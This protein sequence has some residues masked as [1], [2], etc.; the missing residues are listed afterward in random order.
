MRGQLRTIAV[1]R[2]L[3]ARQHGVFARRQLLEKG[4]DSKRIE[5]WLAAELIEAVYRG[6]YA[7]SR[8]LL[9][10]QGRWMAAVLASGQCAVLSH[11]SAAAHWGIRRYAGATE[12]TTP[13]KLKHERGLLRHCLP[14]SPDEVTV[15]DGIPI[16]TPG[17]TLFDIAHQMRPQ[18]L[19]KAVREAEYRRLNEGPSLL[20]LVER[21]PRR[22]GLVAIK[23]L[24]GGGW[25]DSPTR[26]EL[27]LRFATF[28]DKHNL[29][30]PEC[31]ALIDLV[32][33]RYEVDF[34]WR[35]ARLVVELDG[36]SSHRTRHAF[37]ED[38]ER[39]R[40]LQL[41]GFRVIRITWRQLH[42]NRWSLARDLQSLTRS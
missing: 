9:T 15:H 41:A 19:D 22:T 1:A 33:R 28:I 27:E 34:L 39:D 30:R 20:T 14:I 4:V 31:N 36:Y 8:D 10:S 25:S 13:R 42:A 24:L 21:Y 6:V 11:R 3:A 5:R 17:R 16:T 35:S 23:R 38:R 12:V 32:D 26:E 7:L 2:E 40:Q 37:E 18:E 29:P